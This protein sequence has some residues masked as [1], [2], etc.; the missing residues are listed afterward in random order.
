VRC[1]GDWKRAYGGFYT[2]TQGE[3]PDTAK[4]RPT[5]YRASSR[6][7]HGHNARTVSVD[8][9]AL[10]RPTDSASAAAPS[11][12][13]RRR[14]LW[15]LGFTSDISTSFGETFHDQFGAIESQALSYAK[16]IDLLLRQI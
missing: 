12:A 14:L 13:T 3:T 16:Q 1:G 7:Y 10:P 2:G 4:E 5:N 11:I 8:T 6:P 15:W 9:V